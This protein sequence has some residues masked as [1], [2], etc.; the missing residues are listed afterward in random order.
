M[1]AAQFVISLDFELL[2]GVRDN[3]DRETY[4]RNILGARQAIPQMLAL[5]EY[6]GVAA[7]W[8]TVGFLFCGTKDELMAALPPQNLW[9]RY[10][11]P[12]LSSYNYLDEVGVDERRDPYYFG[13]SLIR[14][15][16]A[17]PNQEI[18]T[19]TFAH[20]YCL[21]PGQNIQTLR[22][23]LK[24][25]L[26]LASAQGITL[27]SIVFPRNQYGE[28]HIQLCL[29]MGLTKFRGN[30]VSCLYSSRKQSEQKAILRGLRLID[31]YTGAFDPA[32][33]HR[34]DVSSENIR[35]TR[36]LRPATGMQSLFHRAHLGV[37]KRGMTHAARQGKSYH[38]WWHPHNFGKNIDMNIHGLQDILYHYRNLQDQYGMSSVTM[39]DHP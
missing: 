19:H 29:E 16:R 7:T 34:N 2:W 14:Q 26:D 37:I 28:E 23:D 27:S 22:A 5:F 3:Q 8:A 6:A 32:F 1:I 20:S 35:A 12:R 17:T 21:E 10:D 15:I 24:A 31:A 30:P 39:A 9:P 13:K 33:D 38:L 11:N 4:G 36:F 25:A 18:A